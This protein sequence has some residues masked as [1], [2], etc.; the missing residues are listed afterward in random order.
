VVMFLD[1]AEDQARRRKQ[2]FLRD[3]KTRLDD[4]LKFNERAVL[5]GAGKVSHEKAEAVAEREY[6]LFAARRRALIED[7][8]EADTLKQLEAE[9]K[10]LPKRKK[11][12]KG[13]P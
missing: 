2:V 3:W 4:F 10:K 11:P 1:F 5:P 6:G 12:K 8:A 9:V 7:E 13:K